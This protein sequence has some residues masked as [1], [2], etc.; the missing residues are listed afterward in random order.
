MNEMLLQLGKN[1]KSA[2]TELRN[3]TTNKK[4]EVLEAVADHLVECTEQL[5]SANAIDVEHGKA[6]HMPE[7]LVE[8][9]FSLPERESKEWQRDFVSLCLSKTR[10]VK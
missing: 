4:N 2:E 6:N 1:A 3:I 5:L 10:S 8:P 7:G 9:V